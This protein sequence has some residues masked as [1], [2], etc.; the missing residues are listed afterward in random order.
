M[1]AKQLMQI[2]YD[3]GYDSRKESKKVNKTEQYNIVIT[4]QYPLPID[5]EGV[6]ADSFAVSTRHRGPVMARLRFLMR[7]RKNFWVEKKPQ[8]I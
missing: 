3:D 2:L 5:M 8:K 7:N 6:T 1:D 4:D